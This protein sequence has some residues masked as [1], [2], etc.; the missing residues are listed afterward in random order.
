MK[1]HLSITGKKYNCVHNYIVV[2]YE[3]ILSKILIIN[4]IVVCYESILNKIPI[5]YYQP[6]GSTGNGGV[7]W[8]PRIARVH[9][10][11]GHT[12]CS[13]PP[14]P[15]RRLGVRTQG[16]HPGGAHVRTAWECRTHGTHRNGG[17]YSKLYNI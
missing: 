4:Y 13:G 10:Q 5:N 12:R 6:S 8:P 15:P 2:R 14:R 9:R 11:T 16:D 7:V 1:M 3:N 17:M